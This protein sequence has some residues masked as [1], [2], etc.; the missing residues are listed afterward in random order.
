LNCRLDLR[1]RDVLAVGGLEEVLLAVRELEEAALVDLADVAGVQPA[2]GVERL[3]GGSGL[4][5]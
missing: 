3:G 2:V 5:W 4:L 1:R